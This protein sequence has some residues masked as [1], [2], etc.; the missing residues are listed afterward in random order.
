MKRTLYI[1]LFVLG[2]GLLRLGSLQAQHY[3]GPSVGADFVQTIDRLP[4]TT[5]RLAGGGEI[6][7]AYEWREAHFLLRTGVSY[8]LQCPSLALDSQWLEQEMLDTR[9]VPFTYRGRIYQRTDRFYT[10]QLTVP[11][12]VGGTWRG[13]YFLCGLKLSVALGASARQ[14]A[15]LYTAGD[16]Q[17][18]YYDWFE[19]MPN[20]GYHDGEPVTSSHRI[21]LNR[22]DLRV[23][24]EVGYTFKLN[25]YTRFR[26][27]SRLRVGVF[28]EY[29]LLNLLTGESSAPRTT[30]DWTQYLRVNMTHVYASDE[31]NGSRSNLLVYGIRMT[32]LFP[33]SNS[34]RQAKRCSCVYYEN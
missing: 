12:M 25:P 11:F 2:A 14:D 21:S 34:R 18:R 33:V 20:H 7:V 28:A 23:A 27:S 4:Q 19:D 30:A 16:Y 1:F 31:S 9:G 10:H 29:G 32:V 13:V 26:P 22:F 3:I 5:A 17:G 24:A 15:L 6:G 8:S